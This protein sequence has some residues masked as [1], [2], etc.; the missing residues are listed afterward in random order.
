[1]NRLQF[2]KSLIALPAVT[3]AIVKASAKEDPLVFKTDGYIGT[4]TC[5][6]NERI[7][8]R[9]NGNIGLGGTTNPN[10]KMGAKSCKQQRKTTKL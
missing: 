5:D 2:L 1:M 6:P 3:S 8:I 7:I 10:A 9:T 4:G